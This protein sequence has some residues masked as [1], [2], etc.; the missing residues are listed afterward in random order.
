VEMLS[1]T[2]EANE[3]PYS[4][5][6]KTGKAR[7]RLIERFFNAHCSRGARLVQWRTVI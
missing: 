1:P 6:P 7:V 3:P 4:F 5:F 2:V